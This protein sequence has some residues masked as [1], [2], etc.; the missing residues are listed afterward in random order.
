MKT[1]AEGNPPND[2]LLV[3]WKDIAAYL[4]CSVRKAQRLETRGLPVNRIIGTKSVWASKSEIDR[5]LI[6]QAEKT[7]TR[8]PPKMVSVVRTLPF[9]GRPWLLGLSFALAT[10]T[11]WAAVASQYGLT[12][13]FFGM[14]AA[15]LILAYSLLPHPAYVHGLTGLYVVAGMAYCTSA[16]TLPDVVGSVIN[17]TTLKPALA[18]PVAAGLRFIPIP[19]LITV[20]LVLTP[21]VRAIYLFLGVLLFLLAAG[22]GLMNSGAHRIW[23]AGL[24]VRWTLLAGEC[25]VLGVNIALFVIGY[26]FISARSVQ[27]F[28]ELLPWYAI[29]YLLIALTAAIVTRHWN[30][31]DKY[32]LDIR[33]PDAYR[34]RNTNARDA[35]D[36]WLIH[37]TSEAGSDLVSLFNDPEFLRALQTQN[38]YK[39]DLD[40]FFQGSRKAVIFGYKVGG[41]SQHKPPAFLRIRFPAGLA[42][43]LRFERTP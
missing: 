12:I 33:S 20:A 13:V 35:F 38:F 14:T 11:I 32:H 42:A 3:S 28:R 43:A 19:I 25:F 37:H 36:D 17:M 2:D 9:A 21:R 22:A 34:V 18:Y 30:E 29:G 7:K 6:L 4:K 23:Q 16:T 24:P 41:D 8:M 15:S 31:I 10:A 1:T 26:R 5:W 40:E 27:G 39:Q